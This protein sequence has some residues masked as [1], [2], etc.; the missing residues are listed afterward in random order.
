MSA[1]GSCADNAAA[2]SFFGLLKRERIY[3]RQYRTRAEARTDIFDYIER[4]HNPRKRRHLEMRQKQALGL[5][6]PSGEMG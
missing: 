3:R 4:F 5:T 2:E 6:K 1:V